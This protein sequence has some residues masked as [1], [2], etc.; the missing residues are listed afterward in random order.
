MRVDTDNNGWSKY[1]SNISTGKSERERE[2]YIAIRREDEFR[3]KGRR[4]TLPT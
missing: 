4:F 3:N 1:I 2:E